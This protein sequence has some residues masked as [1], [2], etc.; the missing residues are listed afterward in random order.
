VNRS[1]SCRYESTIVLK[2]LNQKR[3][4]RFPPWRIVGRINEIQKG[5]KRL[6]IDFRSGLK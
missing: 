3:S 6:W 4:K 1:Y 2:E 5:G